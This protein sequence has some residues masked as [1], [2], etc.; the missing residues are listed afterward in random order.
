MTNADKETFFTKAHSPF[1]EPTLDEKIRAN[2]FLS[3]SNH[4]AQFFGMLGTIFTPVQSDISGNVKKLTQFIEENPGKVVYVNDIILMEAG[5]TRSIS[6]DAL[7]WLKRALEFT[8][9]F[10]D[11]IVCDTKNGS[12][13]EDLRPLCLQA[14]EK[15]LEKYHGWMV[16]QIFYLVSRACPSRRD[17]L[18]S[19][20]LGETDMEPT[21]LAQ[22]EE[23]LVNLKKNVAIINQLYSQY[24]LDAEVKV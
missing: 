6:I 19:L 3:A 12:A 17:L 8:M 5:A 2:E 16:Q 15:T 22:M 20:A 18:A 9:L 7:L 23:V 24:N 11:G 4:L 10:I 21:I 14:Y 1:P 13:N